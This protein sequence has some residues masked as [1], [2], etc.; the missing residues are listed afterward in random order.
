M[1]WK[2]SSCHVIIKKRTNPPINQH[3][4]HKVIMKIQSKIL[5][6]LVIA[7]LLCGCLFACDKEEP[8]ISIDYSIKQSFNVKIIDDDYALTYTPIANPKYVD[9]K[10]SEYTQVEYK[11]G[12]IFYV[13]EGISPNRYFYLASGLARQ[14]YLVVIPKCENNL[15]YQ[16]YSTTEKAFSLYPNVKFFVGGHSQGGGAA[17]RRSY[18]NASSVLGMIL[19]SPIGQRHALYDDNNTPVLDENGIHIYISDSIADTAIYT[20][21]LNGEND[22]IRTEQIK[23]DILT[24]LG[25][26]LTQYTI[27]GGTHVGFCEDAKDTGGISDVFDDR[28]GMTSDEKQY[29]LSQTFTLTL[30]FMRTIVSAQ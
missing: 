26:N 1:L 28:V 12:L 13:G 23:A 10:L 18:E 27:Q 20:L 7:T 4:I 8:T 3:K 24:R 25:P 30:S 17:I 29:Q 16:H 19:L 11:Y 2:L 21:L 6:C 5:I 9:G 15:A 22:K 14:G